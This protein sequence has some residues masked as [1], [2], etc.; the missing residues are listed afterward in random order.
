MSYI[1]EA[2]LT[3]HQDSMNDDPHYT[4]TRIRQTLLPLL[5]QQ[6]NPA[7]EQAL[8]QLSSAA[9]DEEGFWQVH[10]TRLMETLGPAEAQNPAE[11]LTFLA[12]SPAEQRR[13]L[14]AYF[15][16]RQLDSSWIQI[17]E[18][19]SLLRGSKPQGEIHLSSEFRF[20][21]R[22]DD[23]F[24]SSPMEP[25]ELLITKE[26]RIPGIT[27]IPE[28]GILVSADILPSNVRSLCEPSALSVEFD[29]DKIQQP[30]TIRTRLE[31]DTIRPLG[32]DGT[33]KVKKIL[34][35]KKVT[36]E[37]RDRIPILCFGGE[38]AWVAGYAYSESF[39]VDGNTKYV[40]KITITPM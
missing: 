27:S 3:F 5:K 40:S 13:M 6:F 36:L 34:Q 35:E 2:G 7:M 12:L 38:I 8:A 1:A 22:Y 10:T 23:F 17:E 16:Q 25:F 20:Y 30:A 24:F 32:M 31:G 19:L 26:I 37:E 11:R 29:A 9:R 39:R 4:R 21:R 33:K 28:L 18:I 14:L 15:Q